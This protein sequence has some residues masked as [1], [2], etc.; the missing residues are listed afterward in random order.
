[1]GRF[2]RPGRHP[3]SRIG[4]GGTICGAGRFLKEQK[5]SVK[6]IAVEPLESPFISKGIFNP[7]RIMGT[8]PGFFP[9]TLNIDLI[10]EIFLVSE[11]QAFQGC[12]L[13]ARKEGLLVGIS[14][15]AVVHSAI[16]IANR[17]ENRDAMIVCIFA[18]TGQRYLS[19]E[20]LFSEN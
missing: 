17:P 2:K 19:V 4:T 9:E 12:R 8:A 13:V 20:G 6:T 15:G 14:T 18:D 1:M 5:A 11:E 7:H 16:Q 3:N 10:D